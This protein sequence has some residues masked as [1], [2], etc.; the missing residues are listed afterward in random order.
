MKV[1]WTDTAIGHLASIHGY[2]AQ[3]SARYARRM[4]YVRDVVPERL[5]N[6]NQSFATFCL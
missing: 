3:D 5:R 2:I 1:R 4:T 6:T